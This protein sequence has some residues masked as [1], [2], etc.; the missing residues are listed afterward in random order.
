MINDHRHHDQHDYDHLHHDHEQ[1]FFVCF[2]G[3]SLLHTT[4]PEQTLRKAKEAICGSSFVV[5]I[6]GI[7][8]VGVV[9]VVV[10]FVAVIVVL[11]GHG[12]LH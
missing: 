4:L 11:D 2:V 1:H 6:V 3:S 12:H 9:I 10:I 5:I 7:I 8:I